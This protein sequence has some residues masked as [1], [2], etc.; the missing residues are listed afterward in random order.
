[1]LYSIWFTSQNYNCV[2][3]QFACRESPNESCLK[4]R[5]VLK[6]RVG[7]CV[8][9][10]I[11]R[12]GGIIIITMPLVSPIYDTLC[13]FMMASFIYF[14]KYLNFMLNFNFLN[15]QKNKVEN[16]ISNP[17][18]WRIITKRPF[19]RDPCAFGGAKF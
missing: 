13:C 8:Y 17:R 1:M 7:A 12:I 15:E 9:P 6:V 5:P 18:Q 11:S 3:K 4:V 14:P 2:A 10:T 19:Y 16:K